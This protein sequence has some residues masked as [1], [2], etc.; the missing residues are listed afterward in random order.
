MAGFTS[1]NTDG[2]TKKPSGRSATRV[3]AA[4]EREARALAD[5]TLDVAEH[6]LAMRL[7]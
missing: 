5:A 7:R 4:V 6:A 3:V 1:S 2:P